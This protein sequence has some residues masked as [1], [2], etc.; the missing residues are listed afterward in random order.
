MIMHLNPH[1]LIVLGGNHIIIAIYQC[2]DFKKKSNV[3][4]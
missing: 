3:L 1:Y 2:C 4:G